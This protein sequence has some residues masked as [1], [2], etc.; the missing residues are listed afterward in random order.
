[1]A[2]LKNSGGHSRNVVRWSECSE[3]AFRNLRGGFSRV[4][5]CENVREKIVGKV[6]GGLRF[7]LRP[8]SRPSAHFLNECGQ[9]LGPL[10]ENRNLG[11]FCAFLI[12]MGQN[13]L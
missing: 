8:F 9:L 7:D 6:L 10:K 12:L 11:R 4:H 1:M 2:D 5:E 13:G 3:V